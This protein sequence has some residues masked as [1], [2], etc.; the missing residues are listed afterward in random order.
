MPTTM[1]CR[2]SG[3][4]PDT[5][6]THGVTLTDAAVRLWATPVAR[7]DQK[8][9]EAHMAMKARMP[10][11]ARTE[12]TSLTVQA[13]MWPTP[14]AADGHKIGA[15]SPETAARQAA[16]GHQEMLAGAIHTA[17]GPPPATTPP[18]GPSGPPK[19][20]LNPAFVESLMG[21]PP[22][23]LTPSTSVETGS[24]QRWL[25]THSLPSPNASASTSGGGEA[26]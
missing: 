3:G 9:P 7:D 5:T 21:L 17:S 12:P 10:G 18:D 15:M 4:N 6:G 11:G 20:D 14:Q 26:A 24:F 16:K 13:K 25:H 23:W 1:D 8:S 19:V 2:R 22:G